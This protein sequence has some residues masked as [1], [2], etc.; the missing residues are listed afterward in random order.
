[1]EIRARLTGY[2]MS[3]PIPYRINE[4]QSDLRSI[5]EGWYAMDEDG[6]LL[7]AYDNPLT[8]DEIEAAHL[9][10]MS[11]IHHPAVMLR[12]V[13]VQSATALATESDARDSRPPRRRVSRRQPVRR[14]RTWGPCWPRAA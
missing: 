9:A 6:N 13:A 8:H 3:D 11:S 5:K 14:R 2:E 1:M 4:A 7:G 12:P 10:G